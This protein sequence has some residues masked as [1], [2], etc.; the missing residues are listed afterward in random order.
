MAAEYGWGSPGDG[1]FQAAAGESLRERREP[2]D[3]LGAEDKPDD[4]GVGRV[5]DDHLVARVH[6]GEQ[7]V[8]QALRA[9]AGDD[10]LALRVVAMAGLFGGEVGDRLAQVEVAGDRQPAVGRPSPA[11]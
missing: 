11:S 4:S 6:G 10:D 2:L 8:E 3:W 7:Y 5:G 9:A 1:L